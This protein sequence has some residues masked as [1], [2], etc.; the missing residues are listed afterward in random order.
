MQIA[1]PGYFS[2]QYLIEYLQF[3]S[4]LLI[5]KI[6]N[7]VFQAQDLQTDTIQADLFTAPTHAPSPR[8]VT[9]LLYFQKMKDNEDMQ[10]FLKS[11]LQLLQPSKRSKPND[12]IA[13]AFDIDGVLL[14]SKS[15]L[16]GAKETLEYFQRHK[17]PFIFLTNGGGHTE[18]DH[19]A[20]LGRRLKMNNL[21]EHQLVQSHSPLKDLGSSLADKRILVLGGVGN[22]IRE[23]AKS[24]GF[25]HVLTSSD[26]CKADQAV[27]PHIE[28]TLENHLEHGDSSSGWWGPDGK[29]K[30]SAI[31]VWFSPRDW[32]L[33]LQVIMN[34]LL[35]E[36]G[37]LGT[38][39]PMNDD[40]NLPNKGYLQ[41]KQLTIYFCNPDLTWATSHPHPRAAQGSFRAALEGVFSAR[42][43]GA[44]L[45]NC[46]TVGK[47]TKETYIFGEK[48]MMEWEKVL[49]GG[50]GKVGTAYVVGDK[51]D[52][53]I[54]GAN[55]FTSI[56]GTEWK[57]I[58]VETGVHVAGEEPA[59]AP[60]AI[61][62]GV[63]E[64]V[65]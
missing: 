51:P 65:E 13:F 60:N 59:H 27:Y 4:I 33:D 36:K 28:M 57:S 6:A 15:P 7:F 61:M 62:K 53:N 21:S 40:E 48:T 18:R 10:A 29:I 1:F 30:I 25:K 31:L 17:I 22:Q 9:A 26:I 52:S 44:K 39:S 38:I 23:L 35:S 16:P 32:G 12:K 50:D 3:L 11:H 14:R 5:F 55:N 47:P 24:Y 46:K 19:V 54:Q 2:P 42:T 20:L 49:N 58:L 56:H 37:Y 34:L 43:G 8:F 41:N 63:R 45:L 64:A